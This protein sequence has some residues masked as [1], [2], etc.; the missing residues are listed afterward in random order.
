MTTTKFTK[1]QGGSVH[2]TVNGVDYAIVKNERMGIVS[3]RVV[4]WDNGEMTL[5]ATFG[6]M[7]DARAFLRNMA[8]QSNA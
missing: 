1:H 5:H 7:R 6:W 4:S 8:A 2:A 3:Y